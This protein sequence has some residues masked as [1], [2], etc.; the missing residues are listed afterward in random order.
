MG[1]WTKNVD[2]GQSP[3]RAPTGPAGEA[4]KKNY[5]AIDWAK[6]AKDEEK[7]NDTEVKATD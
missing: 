2:A 4:Y 1:E 3:S 5:D 7:D 6:P